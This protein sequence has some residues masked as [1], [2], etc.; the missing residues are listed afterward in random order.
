MKRKFVLF[1]VIA[2]AVIGVLTAPSPPKSRGAVA[3][4]LNQVTP[5]GECQ[6][7]RC[8][9]TRNICYTQANHVFYLCKAITNDLERCNSER[10]E[11][12][13]ACTGD[14]W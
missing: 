2:I 9:L 13:R 12:Y 10:E 4:V 14:C 1:L 3:I 6:S 7:D 8:Q 5:T 11:N